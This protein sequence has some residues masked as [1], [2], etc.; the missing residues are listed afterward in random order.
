VTATAA[1]PL[2]D[3]PTRASVMAQ[4]QTEN[5][6]VAMRLVGAQRRAH[7]LAIYG[8]AR[9]VDDAGDEAA[10]DRSALLDWIEGDL[11]RIYAS[12]TPE[13]PVLAALAPTVRGLVLPAR[14]FRRLIEAN[15]RDQVLERYPSFA[16]L[17]DYCEL[18]AAPVG[19]LVLHIC[20]AATPDRVRLSDQICA[21]LQ[22]TEHL[23]D[24]AEDR[25]RGRV[26]LP[27][28]DLE[29]FGCTDADLLARA[30]SRA[31]C[32][33][34][35]FEV[36]RARALLSTGAPLIRRLEPRAALAV[37]GFVA[38]GRAALDA[39]VAA[40]YDVLGARPRPDRRMFAAAFLRTLRGRR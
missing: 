35:A 10:G 16:A 1:S 25:A 23:Q 19:E 32:E 22:V 5:F 39:V 29:R 21:G 33:L 37:A 9:L 26:Y 11:D 8:F 38:G 12:Q 34:M 24:V 27:A 6:P 7:L 4:A 31:F 20:S 17:L 30:P 36:A 3:A 13:H 2:A 18:S 40:G 15:R 14:P 28:E